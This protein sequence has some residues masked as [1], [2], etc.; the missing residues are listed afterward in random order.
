VAGR[1]EWIGL[2]AIALPGLVTVMD[3][4]ILNLAVPKLT[5]DLRPSPSELLW[6][7][8]VYGFTLAGSLLIMGTLGDRIG[9]RRLLLIGAM[10]FAGASL[11]A[12]L[13][14]TALALIAAR[15]LLG[16]AGAT[17][18]PSTLALVRN[19]F[20]DNRQRT[21]AIGLWVGSFSAG[22]ALGPLVG[23]LVLQGFSWR[24]IFLVPIPVM[25]LLLLI[26]PK[27]LPEYRAPY[28]E[29]LDLLSAA[30]SVAA[31]LSAVYALTLAAQDGPSWMELFIGATGFALG[32]VF[33]RRQRQLSHPLIDL[34]LFRIPIFSATAVMLALSAFV[35][36]AGSF[37]NA[38]YLQLVLGLSPL[39]SGLWTLPSAIAVVL[40][41]QL[42]PRL[43]RWASPARVMVG[44]AVVCATGFLLLALVPTA[45]LAVLVAGTI[46]CG[47]GAGLVATLAN[48]GIIGAAPPD[49]A[50]AAAAISQ[51]SIDLTGSL[52][53]AVLGSIGVT[54][55]RLAMATG[56][57]ADVPPGAAAVAH[58]TLGGAVA[59]SH[60]L[61][62][63]TATALLEAARASFGRAYV[64]VA[65]ISVALSLV[66]AV[67]LW[68][69]AREGAVRGQVR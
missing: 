64:A 44:G 63:H 19:M 9:R 66:A 68:A 50:G 12:A 49:R 45:G 7:V 14:P 58:W 1:R 59:V 47:A 37:F 53:I 32:W 13:S 36:F 57:P 35:M 34:G 43:L 69:I 10:A 54:V 21:V 23:G 60:S 46:V 39:Q 52:G 28:V 65:A 30:L 42:A 26:G 16:I 33:L 27:L 38:Q 8:D 6:I 41:S 11:V 67:Q 29:R 61:A 5:A 51:S 24:A 22:A 4:T 48:A 31:I 25:A 55:Y 3:L 17:L 40:T 56:V 2:I 20:L 62:P 18:A 15:A